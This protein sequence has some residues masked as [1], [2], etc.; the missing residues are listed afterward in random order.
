[1]KITKSELTYKDISVGMRV[2]VVSEHVDFYWFNGE[3]GTVIKAEPRHL[4][5]IVKF[6]KAREFIDGSDQDEFN[7]NP[8]NLEVKNGI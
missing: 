6:D 3:V 5:I 1:M 7:F 4:G 8:E 2:K